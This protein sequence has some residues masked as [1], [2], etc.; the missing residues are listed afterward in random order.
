M[1][2]RVVHPE[3]CLLTVRWHMTLL[4]P[5]ILRSVAELRHEYAACHTFCKY[6]PC[7]PGRVS[8]PDLNMRSGSISTENGCGQVNYCGGINGTRKVASQRREIVK[9]FGSR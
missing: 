3:S 1:V 7:R 8:R 4:Q 5:P 9:Y 6:R 2:H